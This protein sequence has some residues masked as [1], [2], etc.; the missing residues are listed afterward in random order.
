MWGRD[1]TRSHSRYRCGFLRRPACVP[2]GSDS[3]LWLPHWSWNPRWWCSQACQD[4]RRKRALQQKTTQTRSFFELLT[5][6]LL[7]AVSTAYV[8]ERRMICELHSVLCLEI[9]RTFEP[10]TYRIRNTSANLSAVTFGDLFTYYLTMLSQLHILHI[11]E[12]D[13]LHGTKCAVDGRV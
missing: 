13:L 9:C 10:R 1:R 7:D 5:D 2:R 11:V 6:S 8:I 4:C 3:W 12:F